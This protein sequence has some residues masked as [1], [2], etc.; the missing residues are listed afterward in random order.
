MQVEQKGG[1]RKFGRKVT[2]GDLEAWESTIYISRKMERFER[3]RQSYDLA[4]A[5]EP[6]SSSTSRAKEC[7]MVCF[8]VDESLV[9]LVEVE[10]EG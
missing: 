5:A 3:A 8:T 1:W 4:K 2:T 9:E 7:S 6:F 10:K